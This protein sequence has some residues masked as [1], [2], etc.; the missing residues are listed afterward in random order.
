VDIIE[1]ASTT[2]DW[3]E[4]LPQ[5][6]LHKAEALN[7]QNLSFEA[8]GIAVPHRIASRHRSCVEAYLQ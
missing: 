7:N 5:K 6:G 8:L 1:L 4:N 2:F 3:L